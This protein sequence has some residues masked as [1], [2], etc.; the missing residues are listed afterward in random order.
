MS[1][2]DVAELRRLLAKATE[3]PW[4]QDGV[5][6]RVPY[7]GEWPGLC[8]CDGSEPDAAL[9]VALVNNAPALLD[10][11]DAIARV[12]AILDGPHTLPYCVEDSHIVVDLI[13]DLRA[14]L[15]TPDNHPRSKP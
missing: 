4:R 7:L 3:R 11:A 14:A 2:V 12:T 15:A 8:D 6:V 1:G 13:R 9:I 5:T 10:A